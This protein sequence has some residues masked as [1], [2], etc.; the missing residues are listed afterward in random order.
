MA[1][2]PQAKE[3]FAVGIDDGRAYTKLYAG[4]GQKLKIRTSVK[5]GVH[6][7]MAGLSAVTGMGSGVYTFQGNQYTVGD[8]IEGEDTRFSDFDGSVINLIAIHHALIRAGF[9]GANVAIATGLPVNS[10]YLG[11]GINEEYIDN[12]RIALAERVQKFGEGNVPATIVQNI[13]FSEAL[14]AWIDYVLDED[15]NV[16]PGADMQNP[17]GVVDFGGRTFDT[18]WINPPGEIDHSR[19]G[20]T[21]VGVLNLF[22]L[23]NVGIQKEFKLSVSRNVLETA[24]QEKRIRLHGEMVDVT[25]IV[26]RAGEEIAAQAEREIHRRFGQAAAELSTI[27][28]VGG[29]V[30]A[31]PQIADPFRNAVIPEDPEF[32]NAR[33]LYKFLRHS[34]DQ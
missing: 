15:G 32:A 30:A 10:Y 27:L 4:N 25:D 24:V 5:A 23:V 6:A 7:G 11:G 1:K 14:A 33:G 9:S 8:L 28:F 16:K 21:N 20:T 19:S 3:V 31:L 13:V 18:L 34:L 29:G 17:V 26:A 2:Q 12:K 22:D